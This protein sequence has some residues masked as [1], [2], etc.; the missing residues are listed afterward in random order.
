MKIIALETEAV[1]RSLKDTEDRESD[2]LAQSK[3]EVCY[4]F[5]Q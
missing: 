3:N 1:A 5:K 4:Y 2:A